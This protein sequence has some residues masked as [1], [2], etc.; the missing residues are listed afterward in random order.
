LLSA[1]L[2]TRSPILGN[3]GQYDRW[4]QAKRSG[5]PAYADLPLTLGYYDRNDIRFYYELAD[6]F[7][8]CDQH[9]CSLHLDM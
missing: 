8:I 2:P 5:E 9:F 6:A 1:F 4:L 7:T 3:G